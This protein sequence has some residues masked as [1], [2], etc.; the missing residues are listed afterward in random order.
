MQRILVSNIGYARGLD[1]G[2]VPHL[3][4]SYRNVSTTVARQKKALDQYLAMVRKYDPDLCCIIEVDTGSLSSHW[5]NQFSYLCHHP[6]AHHDVTV[7]Y[8]EGSRMA[9]YALTRGKSNGFMCKHP[10]EFSKQFF[11]CGSKR[12]VYRLELG[13]GRVMFF[14]HLALGEKTRTMQLKELR[15]L[16]DQEKGEVLIAGDFNILAGLEELD[17]LVGDG[18]YEL[19]NK[20]ED[21]TFRL[22]GNRYL[23]DICVASAALAKKAKLEIIDQPFSDHDALLITL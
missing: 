7:K 13:E 12:L 20:P 4:H 8:V 6:Y 18:R 15:A 1:G 19:L 10:V 23:L 11:S 9:K 5:F 22:F 16:A 3:L 17:I 2:L 21:R 14:T